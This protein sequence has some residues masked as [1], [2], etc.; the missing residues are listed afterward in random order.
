VIQNPNFDF[1]TLNFT[2]DVRLTDEDLAAIL[3][4]TD[5]NLRPLSAHGGK[6][7]H[8]VGCGRGDP[9]DQQRQLL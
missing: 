2:S 6:I 9:S 4:S 3:N 8:Y 7:I 1:R 5:P